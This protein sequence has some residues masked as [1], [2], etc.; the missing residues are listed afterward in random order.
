MLSPAPIRSIRRCCPYSSGSGRLCPDFSRPAAYSACS[1]CGWPMPIR[2]D[3]RALTRTRSLV[4][5]RHRSMI[6]CSDQQSSSSSAAQ[7]W[8]ARSRRT[9]AARR[10]PMLSASTKRRSR[11]YARRASIRKSRPPS[12]LNRTVVRQRLRQP[13]RRFDLRSP[14][15]NSTLAISRPR[16][17]HCQLPA[18]TFRPR[19]TAIGS[20]CRRT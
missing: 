7:G 19:R 1:R 18:T 2:Q 3:S 14:N 6:R 10:I 8:K 16:S 15:R 5:E 4:W 12:S 20:A 13:F 9:S 11:R 17:R